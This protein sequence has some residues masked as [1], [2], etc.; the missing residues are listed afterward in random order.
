MLQQTDNACHAHTNPD[1]ESIERTCI[2][3]VAFA[4]LARCLVQVE[5]NRYTGHEEEEEHYPELL[6][7]L[8]SAIGLPQQTDNSEQQRQAVE[9]VMTLVLFQLFRQQVLIAYKPSVDKLDTGNP[10]AVFYF[11][12]TLQVVLASGEV[13]HE[14]APVHPVELV[15]E[16]ELNVFPLRRHSHHNHFAAFV[17]GYVISL[18]VLPCLILVGMSAAV[19]TGEEHILR[20]LVFDASGDFDVAVFLVVSGLFLTDVFGSVVGDARFAISVFYVQGY[21]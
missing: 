13:P 11:S 1:G 3:V 5:H 15:G 4:R 16:E 14:I 19:H 9:Y 8:L 21:L 17:V 10:V 18:D 6:D 2:C 20:I 7:T 12:A